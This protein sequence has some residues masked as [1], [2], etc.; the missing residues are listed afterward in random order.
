MNSLLVDP[1]SGQPRDFHCP[2][3]RSLEQRTQPAKIVYEM[4]TYVSK[5]AID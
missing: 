3:A 1:M 2:V 4:E 5:I